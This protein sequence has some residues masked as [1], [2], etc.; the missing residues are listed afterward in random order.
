MCNCVSANIQC[1]Y[2][3]WNM[4]KCVRD[5]NYCLNVHMSLEI[6]VNVFTANPT[7]QYS[8]G[9]MCK[10]V[11]VP[12]HVYEDYTLIL[13]GGT[14]DRPWVPILYLYVTPMDLYKDLY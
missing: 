12:M 5:I 3:I 10:C 4:S 2:F 14:L 11:R 8:I 6:Y 9:N 1:K 13:Y 7:F